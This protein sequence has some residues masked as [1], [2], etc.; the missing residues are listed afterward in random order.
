M[1][2]NDLSKGSPILKILGHNLVSVEILSNVS[3]A[4]IQPI[5]R[6]SALRQLT[7]WSTQLIPYFDLAAILSNLT[8]KTLKIPKLNH[9][10]IRHVPKT[11]TTLFSNISSRIV[12]KNLHTRLPNLRELHARLDVPLQEVYDFRQFANL[13]TLVLHNNNKPIYVPASLQKLVINTPCNGFDIK[14]NYSLK[15]VKIIGV[16][17]PSM[18]ARIIKQILTITSIQKI[19]FMKCSCIPQKSVRLFGGL[20][21]LEHFQL[22]CPFNFNP[23]VLKRIRH[24]DV[25]AINEDVLKTMGS[26]ETL[27]HV[28][29]RH[30]DAKCLSIR[31]FVK[32]CTGLQKLGIVG[33]FKVDISCLQRHFPNIIIKST[34]SPTMSQYDEFALQDL[35]IVSMLLRGVVVN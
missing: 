13:D 16:N 29:I 10:T 21:E 2:L 7:L 33:C 9:V 18:L 26:M 14:P 8:L 3:L 25:T 4:A 35:D 17:D 31:N 19:C 32:G 11:L 20:P 24:L 12:W 6:K 28:I 1:F 30:S 34:L 22:R 23:R 27:K 15:I 5:L